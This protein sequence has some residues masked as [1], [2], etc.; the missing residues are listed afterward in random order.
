MASQLCLCFSE[1]HIG[2][3]LLYKCTCVTNFSMM[4]WWIKGE[5]YIV[6]IVEGKNG[7]CFI[8]VVLALKV[9]HELR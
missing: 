5:E 3:A 1:F 9:V 2:L 7:S 8:C 4:E 6:R